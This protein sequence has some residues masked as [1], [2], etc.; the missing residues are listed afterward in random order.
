MTCG[1]TAA[2]IPAP[3]TVAEPGLSPVA[4]VID[5]VHLARQTAGDRDLET[6]L[7]RLFEKQCQRAT[8]QLRSGP[9]LTA[10]EKADLAH[11][12]KGSAQA[13]GA[14]R[15]AQAAER[16]ENACARDDP[17]SSDGKELSAL[18]GQLQE[19]LAQAGATIVSWLTA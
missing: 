5:L 8:G 4:P 14:V 3:T 7:L 10:A 2:N 12:I 17:G 15:V 6:E 18:S 1:D 16:F 9:K 11:S 19:A 13:I